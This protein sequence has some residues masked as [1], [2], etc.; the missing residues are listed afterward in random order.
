MFSFPSKKERNVT[1]TQLV[2]A[3]Y[4][5]QINVECCCLHPSVRSVSSFLS[6]CVILLL[7]PLLLLLCESFCS[8]IYIR[9]YAPGILQR[10]GTAVPGTRSIW[11]LVVLVYQVPSNASRYQVPG[12]RYLWSTAVSYYSCSQVNRTELYR[13]FLLVARTVTWYE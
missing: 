5:Y 6:P 7:L 9:V 13:T 2:F 4:Q 3:T 1:R 11:F 8:V 10:S 12:V